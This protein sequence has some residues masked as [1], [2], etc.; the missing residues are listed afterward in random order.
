MPYPVLLFQAAEAWKTAHNG[1]LPSTPTDK[2]AFRDSIKAASRNWDMEMNFQEAQQNAYLGFT[3]RTVD[4]EE[5]KQLVQDAKDG[6]LPK[7][8]A[9]VSALL[10]FLERHN[11]QAPLQGTIPDMTASTDTYVR[12]Q[13]LYHDKAQADLKE[14][15]SLVPTTIVPDDADLETFC[16]NVFNLGLV[17]TGS[18]VDELD[19]SIEPDE[20]LVD[21]WGM[22]TFDPYEVPEHTPLLW[23]MAFRACQ[24]FY[25]E[26]G[27]YPGMVIDGADDSFQQDVDPLHQCLHKVAAAMKLQENDLV[28]QT[29]LDDPE[30]KYAKEMARYANAEIH[31]VASVLGGVGSQEAVKIITGQ[32]VPLNNTYIYNGIVSTG[33][34]YKF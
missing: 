9:M 1:S 14:I 15:R 28:K 34:V 13:Q 29:L 26:Y 27:R 32:Y 23:Y 5:M 21:D 12:L 6:K 16:K 25:T 30:K 22:A 7:L 33:G 4:V 19:P 8:H 2:Q 20:E 31:N 24:E 11:G 18:I 3:E 17:M 10:T